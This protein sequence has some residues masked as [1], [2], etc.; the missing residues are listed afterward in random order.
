MTFKIGDY[1]KHKDYPKS[2][3]PIYLSGYEHVQ[4]INAQADNFEYSSKEEHDEYWREE[5]N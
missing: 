3:V 4:I 1:V 5:V 2:K